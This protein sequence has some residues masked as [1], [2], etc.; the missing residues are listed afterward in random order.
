MGEIKNL[1]FLLETFYQAKI[2][3]SRTRIQK[4]VF[5]EKKEEDLPYT[6]QFSSYYYGPF[7]RELAETISSLVADGTLQEREIVYP[8]LDEYGPVVEHS[9][10]LTTFGRELQ[11]VYSKELTRQEKEKIKKLCDKHDKKSLRELISYV[12]ARY[13]KK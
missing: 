12:Y 8:Y 2:S 13:V 3:Y 1:A 10:S 5:L 4:I 11:K 9:Y 7:S 6:Y